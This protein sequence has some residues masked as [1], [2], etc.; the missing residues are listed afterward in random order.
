MQQPL[1]P[2]QNQLQW[3]LQRSPFRV[4]RRKS[5]REWGFKGPQAELTDEAGR[6]IGKPYG[7]PTWEASDAS[8]VVARL[9]SS[10]DSQF[11]RCYSPAVARLDSEQR[12]RRTHQRE[13]IQRLQTGDGLAPKEPCQKD[14]LGRLAQSPYKAVY[15]FYGDA[16]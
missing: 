10:A 6:T 9:V 12:H 4:Q 11:A 5:G 3:C 16:R 13:N 1:P 2:P 7:G 15:Y 8:K 14:G